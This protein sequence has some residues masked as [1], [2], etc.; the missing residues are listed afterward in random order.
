VHILEEPLRFFYLI[1]I[2]GLAACETVPP[3]QGPSSP[4]PD[5]GIQDVDGDGFDDSVDCDDFNAAV[6]PG[7]TEICDN[8]DNDCNDLVDDEPADGTIYY[9]DNDGDYYGDVNISINACAAPSGYTYVGGDCDD[10]NPETHAYAPEICDSNDNDC[11]SEIDEG[12]DQDQDGFDTVCGQDCDDSNDEVHPEAVEVC[13]GIDNNCVDGSDEGTAIDAITYY[14]DSDADGYGDP[15]TALSSCEQPSNTVTDNTD[16]NDAEATANPDAIEIFDGLDNDC[17]GSIDRISLGDS[18][19]QLRGL[20]NNAQTGYAVD[21]SADF[22]NDGYADLVLGA[23]NESTINGTQSGA[24]YVVYG[25]VSGSSNLTGA[26]AVLLGENP[27]D[28]AGRSVAGCDVDGDGM[29]D[30]LMGVWGSDNTRENAGAVYVY[31]SPFSNSAPDAMIIGSATGDAAGW[32]VACAGDVDGDGF[33]DVIVGAP[34]N[35]A[36]SSNAGAAHLVY[37]PIVG[38]IDLYHDADAT[39]FGEEGSDLAGGTVAGIGDINGDGYDD[40]MVGATYNKGTIGNGAGAAYIVFGPVSGFYNLSYADAKLAGTE[41]NAFA[42]NVAA[43][44]DVDGDGT[45]D[46]IVGAHGVDA[47]GT[48]RGRAYLFYGPVS[49]TYGLNAADTTVSGNNDNDWLGL[50]VAGAG[51]LNNDGY[52]DILIGAPQADNGGADS[53]AAYLFYGPVSIGN[54]TASDADAVFS[55]EAAGDNSGWAVSGGGDVDGDAIDDLVIGARFESTSAVTAGGAAYLILGH[56][57]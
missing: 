33:E 13:D 55:G 26:D 45:V 29:D 5:T 11:D 22:N 27:T 2:V 7:A 47:G 14:D 36:A 35:S 15:A 30:V 4:I 6:Y 17:E 38:N 24:A 37:G 57:N 25:P 19:A 48:D 34:K 41:V 54:L 44:G 52:D 12:D 50:A 42:R 31:Y 39:F 49:G 53:G 51:D 8:Q 46:V 28:Y 1:S 10:T 40:I 43:A 16:C 21:N 3:L 20:S 23:T 56:D 18:H 9:P 32:S